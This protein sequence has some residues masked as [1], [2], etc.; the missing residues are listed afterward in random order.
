MN[1]GE[2]NM[3][4]GMFADLLV[5]CFIGWQVVITICYALDKQWLNTLYWGGAIL[6]TVAVLLKG[7]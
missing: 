5:K 6:L 7:K 4:P 1:P 2:Y 3:N